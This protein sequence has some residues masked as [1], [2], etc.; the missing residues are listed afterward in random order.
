MASVGLCCSAGHGETKGEREKDM[1]VKKLIEKKIK[2]INFLIE[3][4]SRKKNFKKKIF[5]F[6]NFL[7]FT[8]VLKLVDQ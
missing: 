1:M 4:K 3:K 8:D 7:K 5:F 6:N 2:L